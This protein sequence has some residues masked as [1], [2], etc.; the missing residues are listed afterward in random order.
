MKPVRKFHHAII[1]F[2]RQQL[3]FDEYI[4]VGNLMCSQD[5]VA[6]KPRAQTV[7]ETRLQTK[8]MDSLEARVKVIRPYYDVTKTLRIS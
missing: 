4:L 2:V 6:C 8:D 5:N 3:K 1:R 7:K